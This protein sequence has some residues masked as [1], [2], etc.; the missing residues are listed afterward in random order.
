MCSMPPA[1]ATSTAPSAISP[2]AAVTAVSAPAHMRSTA[3]PGTRVGDA[4]EQRD[5][6]AERQALV[7]DLRGRRED[8][9][10]DPLGAGSPGCGAAARARP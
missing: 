3:K 9:V 1:S 8:D 10:A 2:A 6:A 4:R 7:A 5:V